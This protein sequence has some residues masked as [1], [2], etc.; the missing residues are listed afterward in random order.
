MEFQNFNNL[1]IKNSKNG[2]E[3]SYDLGFHVKHFIVN[4]L[5]LRQEF[6]QW[7]RKSAALSLLLLRML[8]IIKMHSEKYPTRDHKRF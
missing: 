7:L 1:R 3:F 8:Y 2:F 6:S 4:A 5:I